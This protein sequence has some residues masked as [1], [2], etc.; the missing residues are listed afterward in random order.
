M[1]KF[2]VIFFS[3]LYLTVTSGITMNLHYCGGKLKT[4]SFFSNN[5]KG[6]CGTKKKS[7]GCCKDKTKLIKVE[8]NHKA[9]K[10][11]EAS[12]PTVHLV[13]LLS[14]QLLFNL[15]NDNSVDIISKYYSPPVLYDNPLYLK[16]QVLLI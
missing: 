15:S 3:M 11:T 4:V 8:E 7:K 13:A 5:E 1:Q 9:S 2:L 14:S 10:V 16:H 6:C 12:N